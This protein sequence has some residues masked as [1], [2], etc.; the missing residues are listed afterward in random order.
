MRM[1]F[2]MKDKSMRIAMHVFALALAFALAVALASAQATAADQPTKFDGAWNVVMTCPPHNEDEDAKGYTHR[3]PVSILNGQ[4]RAV[5]G[6]EGE[7]G[8]HLLTGPIAEDG[9]ATL[10][11]EGIVNNAA[12]AINNAQRGKAYK[13]R[14]KA[15]FQESTGIGQ[16]LTGRVCTFAFSR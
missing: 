4:L 9:S 2:D 1:M 14:V 10:R 7:P 6:T 12:Y 13:Y 3:F 11:L 15:Q 8:W 16:R 5:H